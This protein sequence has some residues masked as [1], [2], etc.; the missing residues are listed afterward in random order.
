MVMVVRR[1]AVKTEEHTAQTRHFNNAS[2]FLYNGGSIIV[3][4]EDGTVNPY[5]FSIHKYK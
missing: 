5:L 4:H 3:Y 1:L 2:I